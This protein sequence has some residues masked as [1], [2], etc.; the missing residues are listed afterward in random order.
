MALN[1]RIKS[2][3][4]VK[5]SKLLIHF[6]ALTCKKKTLWI[7]NIKTPKKSDKPIIYIFWHRHIFFNIFKFRNTNA[8]PLIS[9]S[10]DGELVSKI[11]EEFGMNPIRG[12]SSKGGVKAFFHMVNAIKKDNSEIMITADGPKGPSREVKDGTIHIAKKTGAY[13][14]P[15]S[16]Y[17]TRL[18][19]FEK[20]WDKFMLPLPFGKIVFAY[21]EPISIPNKI[22][23]HEYPNYRGIIKYKLDDLE[24]RVISEL[25]ITKKI[26]VK[27]G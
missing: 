18:K 21:G 2:F 26:E 3:L 27:N 17:A 23:K 14:I 15:V 20:S 5:M 1:Q 25:G 10:T 7:E 8:R 9:Y 24:K 11:A 4:I 13:I 16:W 12:S 6:I 19:I 22:L